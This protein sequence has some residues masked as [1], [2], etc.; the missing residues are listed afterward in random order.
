MAG[1]PHDLSGQL[2]RYLGHESEPRLYHWA[3]QAIRTS[4]CLLGGS[5]IS[6]KHLLQCR[7]RLGGASRQSLAHPSC[8]DCSV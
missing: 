3:P 8:Y 5:A 4:I 2:R 7:L 6:Q 1:G